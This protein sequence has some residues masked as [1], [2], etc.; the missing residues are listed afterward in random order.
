MLAK[1]FTDAAVARTVA[2]LKEQGYLNDA[3]LAADQAERLRQRGF[4]MERVRAKLRQKGV[5]PAIIE[6]V[7]ASDE[8]SDELENARRFLASRFS[9][10]ALKQPKIVARAFRLLLNRGYSQEVVEQLL[11]SR[12]DD[13]WNSEEE[14]SE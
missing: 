13:A 1:G 12:L 10:D 5:S 9:P 6:R 8:P 4:G 14:E 3:L 11:E 7:F 2:R